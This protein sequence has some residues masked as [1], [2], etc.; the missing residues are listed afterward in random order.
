MHLF[1]DTETTGFVEKS[2]PASWAGQPHLVQLAA[3]L[4]EDDGPQ[5]LAEAN[6][7]VRPD[8]YEI[9]AGAVATQGI[10][11][12]LAKRAGVPLMLAVATFVHL[13]GL[14]TTLVAH[15]LDFDR[16]VMDAAI[17]RVGRKPSSDGPGLDAQ[18]CTIRMTENILQLPPT[19]RMIAAGLSD[20]YKGPNLTEAHTYFFGEGFE[21]AHDALAD[22]RACMRVY[23][24][25]RE[26]MRAA[27]S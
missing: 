23:F 11:T 27:V 17:H 8:G 9:P 15:N 16:K 13:R 7:I 12:E 25:A 2:K 6:L 5:V 22:C 21:G 14:A 20:K 18:V 3:I 10:T 26:V 19:E 4:T 1:Y 24:A